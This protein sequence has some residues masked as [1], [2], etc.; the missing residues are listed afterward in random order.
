MNLKRKNNDHPEGG[1]YELFAYLPKLW[2]YR[3]SSDVKELS[4]IGFKGVGK[5]E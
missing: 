2:A 1:V 3:N 5:N 4:T